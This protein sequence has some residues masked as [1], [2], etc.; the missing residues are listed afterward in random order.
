ME[1]I[2]P[3][4]LRNGQGLLLPKA[5]A[6][7][8]LFSPLFQFLEAFHPP[9]Y[10]LASSERAKGIEPSVSSLARKRFTGKLR[11]QKF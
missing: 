3:F 11:P 8:N 9:I 1:Y 7:L 6:L 5:Q 4:P 10:S 2:L